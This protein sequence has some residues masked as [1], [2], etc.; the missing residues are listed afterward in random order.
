MRGVFNF[1]GGR[2]TFFALFFAITAF[3]LAWAGKLT[4]MYIE[5]MVTLQAYVLA[6]SIKEDHYAK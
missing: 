2:H 4:H 6:H 3:A 1:F 5:V